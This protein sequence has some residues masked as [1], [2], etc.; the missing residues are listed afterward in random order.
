MAIPETAAFYNPNVVGDD[1]LEI[2][3]R[4]WRQAFGSAFADRFPMIK[5]IDWFEWRK[6]EPEIG[7]IVDWTTTDSPTLR[8]AFAAEGP[9]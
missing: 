2:K 8:D 4:W 9:G 3:Q 1:E 5:L 6:Y 7:G